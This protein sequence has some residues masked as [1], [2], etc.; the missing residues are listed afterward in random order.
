M[1]LVFDFYNSI[2]TVPSP[3]TTLQIQDLL[4]EI[5]NVED[6]YYALGYG[7]IADAFGKQDL[8]GG[9]KVG[10]TM[11]LQSPWRIAFEARPGPDTESC[12]IDGGNLVGGLNNNPI[13][14]TAFT[15]V[16][17]ANSSSAT[18]STPNDTANLKYLIESLYG[19]H[20]GVGNTYYWDPVDGSDTNDGLQPA[21]AVKTFTKV[22]L[23][24][25]S[26]NHDIVYCL[27]ND[28]S[29]ITTVTDTLSITKNGVKIRGPGYSFQLVPTATTD[30]TI[31]I[32][33]HSVQISG[34]YVSTAATGSQN[35]ITVAGANNQI[36]DSWIT[37]ARG[38]CISL[39]NTDHTQITNCLIENSGQSGTGDGLY[40]GNSCVQCSI[41]KNVLTGNKNGI[42]LTGTSLSNNTIE[43]NLIYNN[44]L[45][46]I[47]VGSGVTRTTVR[48]A[49][50]ITNNTSGNTQDLGTDTYIETPAGGA[51]ASDVADA[52]WD[53][54][55]ASHTISGSTGKTLK[56]AKTKATL[57][58]I[59]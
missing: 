20:M 37:T 17:M 23:L 35:A 47:T 18:I 55:I 1:A 46:G 54:L 59:Q 11:V 41:S 44:S 22:N 42:N 34:L 56:D 40:L 3:Q 38:H 16:T 48:S 36:K 2:I 45:Y 43:N 10:I 21:S 25:T 33:A 4:D 27:A 19:S 58:S 8:G 5:R 49:N 6:E 57:A 9:V 26:N 39:A 31:N 30:P 15:Q 50:T 7:H 13:A 53:E 28:P 12:R 32:N 51:S 29:G 52:V 24:V 14:P